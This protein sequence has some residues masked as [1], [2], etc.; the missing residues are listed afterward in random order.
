ME[1]SEPN[2]KPTTYETMYLSV[3]IRFKKRETTKSKKRV[4]I[5]RIKSNSKI[6][7]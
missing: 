5:K 3:F 6:C 7:A 1:N 2:G 4:I